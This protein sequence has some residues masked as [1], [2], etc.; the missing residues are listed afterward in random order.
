M[1]RE[2]RNLLVEMARG[3]LK[4][5]DAPEVEVQ[6][7]RSKRVHGVVASVN[8]ALAQVA[9]LP[10]PVVVSKPVQQWSEPKRG[11]AV[12]VWTGDRYEVGTVKAV[13]RGEPRRL[14]VT[15]SRGEGK[16]AKK[17]RVESD[18]AVVVKAWQP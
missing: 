6:A 1:D 14:W 15:I 10:D 13:C 3:I 5:L 8:D 4:V 9:V 11:D 2:L 18:K 17:V 16:R 12:R 7:T